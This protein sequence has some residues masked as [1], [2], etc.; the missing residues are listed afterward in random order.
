MKLFAIFILFVAL[1][2]RAQDTKDIT[3]KVFERDRDKDGKPDVRIETV[4]RGKTA[5]LRVHRTIKGGVTNT[6]R[7]Y[8][9][10]GDSVMTES[11]EDGDGVFETVA[12]YHPAK[13]E[14]EVFTR[15]TDG[16]V[17]PVS[18]QTLAAYKK[19]HAAISEFWDNAFDKDTDTDK[20]M[21][22]MKETQK[23]IRDAEKEKTDGKK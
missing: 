9:V 14:M 19:Q 23:K 17:R 15:Q 10:A 4:S 18:A 3:T 1:G 7:S 2:C 16:S 13:T 6:A 21:E 8:M 11:D 20:A 22:M 12:I 5:I